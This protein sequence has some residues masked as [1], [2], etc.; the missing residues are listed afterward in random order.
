M[1][2]RRQERTREALFSALNRLLEKKHF[3]ELSVQ[4]LLDE[5]NIGRS[6]FYAHFRTK[7][8]VAR[9]LCAELL[10]HIFVPS[11][12]RAGH[13]HGSCSACLAQGVCRAHDHPGFECALCHILCHLKDNHA[14]LAILFTEAGGTL[15]LREFRRHLDG[16]FAR[17]LLRAAPTLSPAPPRDFLLNTLAGSFLEMVRWWLRGHLDCPSESLAQ[18]F[19]AVYAAVIAEPEAGALSA[20]F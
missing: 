4:E 18:W 14:R 2:D 6:T 11:G 8:D 9:Q 10:G 17:G 13:T 20:G 15:F 12:E 3:A 5:A 19:I 7:E 16:L 1:M